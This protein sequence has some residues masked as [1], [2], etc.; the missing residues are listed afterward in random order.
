MPL[1]KYFQENNKFMTPCW[2]G[3]SNFY[4][5]CNSGVGGGG[6]GVQF[7][8][9]LIMGRSNLIYENCFELMMIVFVADVLSEY[10]YSRKF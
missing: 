4:T 9:G 1:Y 7:V 8:S 5:K 10:A 2:S 3:A 6:R